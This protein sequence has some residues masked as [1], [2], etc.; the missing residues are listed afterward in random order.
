[1]I[2]KDSYII[3]SQ[4]INDT[5]NSNGEIETVKDVI[6]FLGLSF[7]KPFA[8]IVDNVAVKAIASALAA[9][10]AAPLDL[11]LLIFMFWFLDLPLG[12]IRA[13]FVNKEDFLPTK[14][15]IW[16]IRG[17]VWMVGLGLF[18][19]LINTLTNHFGEAFIYAQSFVFAVVAFTEFWSNVRSL[20]SFIGK[21]PGET[22]LGKAITAFM[23]GK[24]I[25]EAMKE[26]MNDDPDNNNQPSK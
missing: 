1:M 10:F 3:D 25:K 8:G 15:L 21:T 14:V 22:A 20:S 23:S 13:K 4:K 16:F 26:I 11:T 24:G 18:S 19:A 12:V 2:S 5:F 17:I 9:M 7:I 6:T